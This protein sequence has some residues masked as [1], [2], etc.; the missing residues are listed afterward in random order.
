MK[1]S[2]LNVVL[3]LSRTADLSKKIDDVLGLLK[4]SALK[5]NRLS[6]P[7]LTLPV[8]SMGRGWE[9]LDRIFI[10]SALISRGKSVDFPRCKRP[11][12]TITLC[13]GVFLASFRISPERRT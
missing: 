10:F 5:S 11:D 4:S 9:A 2:D 6:N 13:L 12:T 1:P 7:D 8:G 3:I